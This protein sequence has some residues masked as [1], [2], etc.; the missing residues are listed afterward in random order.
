MCP[1]REGRAIF[2]ASGVARR[3]RWLAPRRN[4]LLTGDKNRLGEMG[5]YQGGLVLTRDGGGVLDNE[6]HRLRPGPTVRAQLAGEM[7]GGA[8]ALA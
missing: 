4:A 7:H 1:T 3:L 5:Q 2:A 6:L 8:G